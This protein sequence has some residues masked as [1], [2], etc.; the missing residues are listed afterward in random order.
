MKRKLMLFVTCL[1]I[2]IGLVNAQVKVTGNV[3][4]S[5]DGLPI[6]GA[7]IL[8]KGTT[9]G[10]VTD[11]DG[12]F[13][14]G[15]VPENAKELQ[16]SFV[17]MKTLLVNVQ[18]RLKIVLHPDSEVLEDVVVVA[19]GTA[20]KQS[21]TGAVSSV[22]S[23]DLELR[24][25]TDATGALEG[26]SPGVQVNNSYGEPGS[27]GSQ[28]R[29]RGFG[30]INGTND[31]LVVVDGV[32][33]EGSLNDI[34]SND[35]ESMS[36]LKDAA[37]A[38]LYGNKAAN[39]VILIT[40][41]SG[42]KDRFSV[43]MNVKQ[44]TYN[45]G[46]PEYDRVGIKDWMETQWKGY[47]RYYMVD[48]GMSAADAGAATTKTLMQN[49]IKNNIFDKP[50]D[51]LFDANGKLI[52]NV[53]P[54]YDDL[55]WNDALQRAGYRQEYNLSTDG[56][57]EKYDMF[58][59]MSYLNE[60]GYI[61]CSDFD[62]L[63][64]RFKANFQPVKWFKT[65]VNVSAS[66]ATSNFA[67]SASG[68]YFINPFYAS[69]M[70]APVYPLYKH[71]EDG[72][73]VLDENGNKVYNLHQVYLNDRH[74]AYELEND[75]NNRVRNSINGQIYGT[76]NFLKDFSFTVKAN[77]YTYNEN[78]KGYNNPEIGDGAGNNGR[79]NKTYIRTRDYNFAQELYWQHDFGKHHVDVLAAHEAFK[80]MDHLDYTMKT[81]Q[82]LYGNNTE[83]SNFSETL[84]SEGSK[85]GYTTE[86]YLARAR[87]NFAKR[88]YVD[89]S[90]RRDGSSRFYEPWGN[91]WSLGGNWMISE[92]SFMRDFKWVNSL[93][94][95]ASYGEVGNDAGVGY[96]AYKALYGSDQNSGLGAYYKTQNEAKNLKWETSSTLDIAL[97]GRFFHRLNVS[98]D[99]FDKRSNDLLFDVF[100]PLS[101]GATDLNGSGMSSITKNIG[102]VS[103]K[104]IEIAMDVDAIQ[105]DDWRWNIGLNMTYLKNKIVELPDGKDILNGIRKFSEGHSI[106]EFYTYQ[107][108]GVDQMT[109][110][111][112]YNAGENLCNDESVA[113]GKSM[114]IN[115]KYYVNDS[116][117]G[118][119][120]WSGSALP[121]V[122]GSLSSSLSW[123]SLT[124]SLLCTYSL[125]GKLY[126]SN[127]AGLMGMS[128]AS[129]N[130]LHKDILK[131]WTEVPAGMTEDS[132]NRIDPNGIP[133]ADL[134]TENAY[135]G[136]AST[137]WLHNASYFAIKNINLN[138]AFPKTITD[139]L[140]IGGL[141]VFGAVENAATF[142][143][144]KGTNPQY[145]FSGAMDNTFVT[146]RV[147]SF[148]LNLKF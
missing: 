16:V 7:S 77:L 109:G 100:N 4:S 119:K 78:Q 82:K 2:G 97:E 30:S 91:F 8:V 42:H 135:M 79:L 84:Y 23:K 31:P 122:Y 48:K 28:I 102:S 39:G 18:S 139:K 63:S 13:T 50:Q 105:N 133:R 21:L 92:E 35:I 36:V 94:L 20:S 71:N 124:L 126:E 33:Y 101:A 93:K 29:I 65:G 113:A 123:K 44:G 22:S 34:N 132:P 37:S 58:A 87:Y 61:N 70:M 137:R 146:A 138:Y 59:S 134:S 6:V 125:G 73:I 1:F 45:R 3:T 142:T 51:Q 26:T 90:F 115:G 76:I 10:T 99:F 80:H 64:A 5:E 120:E 17:G 19:Y 85:S 66:S 129:P 117:K 96:Y 89:A 49:I 86:S 130:A 53:L 107:Y 108:A 72:S 54:G 67:S 98:L 9:I 46:I 68:S 24:P 32:V 11:L 40:T 104:G 136:G 118:Q 25:V 131:S 121:K 75:V 140:G 41:K 56:G 127:Y 106:Y 60:K 110:L 144:M 57:G 55:D 128:A 38:A 103:N 27:G 47:Q 95:R 114:K 111:P 112:L 12:N 74:I 81:N 141:D 14:L 15:N 148:G 147:F 62:R 143:S 116:S 43:R 83:L 145:S 88:Y 69:R 52:A